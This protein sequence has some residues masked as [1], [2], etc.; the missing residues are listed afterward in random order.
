MAKMSKKLMLTKDMI[1]NSDWGL[2]FPIV[3]L[4]NN[5]SC[6]I[7]KWVSVEVLE[8]KQPN[9]FPFKIRFLAITNVWMSLRKML[10][11]S[12]DHLEAAVALAVC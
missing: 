12:L 11:L 10:E 7:T 5:I 1:K 4:F 6:L 3:V 8:Y 9:K 2:L